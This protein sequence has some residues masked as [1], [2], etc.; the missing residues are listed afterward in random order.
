MVFFSLLSWEEPYPWSGTAGRCPLGACNKTV[1]LSV[2]QRDEFCHLR[3]WPRGRPVRHV[4]Q[5][6]AGRGKERTGLCSLPQH[7]IGEAVQSRH[8][9]GLGSHSTVGPWSGEPT[10]A[11]GGEN[12]GIGTAPQPWPRPQV[13][14][15]RSPAAAGGTRLGH[16]LRRQCWG[17]ELL[18]AARRPCCN[19]TGAKRAHIHPMTIQ[20][21]PLPPDPLTS[22]GNKEPRPIF[23]GH[24]V[25]TSWGFSLAY[26]PCLL[27]PAESN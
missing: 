19:S 11:R 22:A 23:R 2:G 26:S 24:L 5:V 6:P 13:L 12:Q 8:H 9:I 1:W 14:R 27:G 16:R 15:C 10:A 7:T 3:P 20:G 18:T 17:G 25:P 4:T 21:V